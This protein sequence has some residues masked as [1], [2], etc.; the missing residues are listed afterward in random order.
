MATGI[1]K[2]SLSITA[3][4]SELVAAN[5]DRGSVVIQLLSGNSVALGLG[6]A[7]VYGEGIHLVG[8]G[9]S[10]TI[11]GH[12]ARKAIN[13]ICDTGLSATGGYQES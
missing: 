13:G 12:Q 5:L 9:S 8:I 3:T 1:S 11:K 7:A 6:E 10:V 4:T 2:G